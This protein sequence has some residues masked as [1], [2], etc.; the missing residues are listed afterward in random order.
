MAPRSIIANYAFVSIAFAHHFY[1]TLLAQFRQNTADGAGLDYEIKHDG[2]RVI[3]L[4][5]GK[6]VRLIS[7]KGKDLSY[8]FP[9]PSKRSR[10]CRCIRASSTAKP[11]SAMPPVWPSSA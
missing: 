6:K 9:L 11:S 10:H 7:R 5:D 8:R 1:R 2:F 4:R 3:A